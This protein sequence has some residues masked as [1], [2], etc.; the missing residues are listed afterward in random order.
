[1]RGSMLALLCMFIRKRMFGESEGCFKHGVTGL[2]G[3][4]SS[5][6]RVLSDHPQ[7]ERHVVCPLNRSGALMRRLVFRGVPL[8]LLTL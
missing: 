7:S 6:P 3:A 8:Q 5:V 2:K 1:M 4:S